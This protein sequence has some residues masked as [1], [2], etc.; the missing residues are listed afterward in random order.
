[1]IV[2]AK[3]L[4]AAVVCSRY[5][6]IVPRPLPEKQFLVHRRYLI[7]V[8]RLVLR[9]LPAATRRCRSRRRKLGR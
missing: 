3:R 4:P 7:V 8:L 6:I 1:L 5:L 9:P 2:V